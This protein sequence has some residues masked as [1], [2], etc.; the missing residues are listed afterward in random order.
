MYKIDTTKIR[1]METEDQLFENVKN[2]DREKFEMAE[3]VECVHAGKRAY[4]RYRRFMGDRSSN[5]MKI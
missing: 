4:W 3:I 1:Q 2:D 5:R